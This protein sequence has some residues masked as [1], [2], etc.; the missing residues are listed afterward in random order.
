MIIL[1][2]LDKIALGFDDVL[3]LKPLFMI[4]IIY[5]QTFRSMINLNILQ[6]STFMRLND[7]IKSV[8]CVKECIDTTYIGILMY[9]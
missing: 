8:Y 4:Y 2:F 6:E 1:H 5:P 7:I 9:V 3:L